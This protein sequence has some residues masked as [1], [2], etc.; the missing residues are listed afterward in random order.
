[1]SKTRV[2]PFPIVFDSPLFD[3]AARIVE[4]DEDVF[5]ETLLPQPAV[6]A[7][8][9]G[10]LNRLARLDELQLHAAFVGPLIEYAASKFRAIIRGE[11]VMAGD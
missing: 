1:M 2:R 10:V 8:D 3:F 5:V 4:R 11:A 9:E 6:E 7:L